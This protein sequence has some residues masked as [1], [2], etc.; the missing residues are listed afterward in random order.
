MIIDTNANL[1][2]WPFRRT[3]CDETESLIERLDR[4]QITSAWTGSLDGLFHRDVDG[5]NKRL[6]AECLKHRQ[7][8]PFGTVNPT[9]P[10]WEQ[11]L[12][13]CH[14]LYMM[15]GIRLHPNYHGYTI[16]D[17]R[18]KRLLTMAAERELIVQLAIRMD[19]TRVQH[20]LMQVAD[21]DVEPLPKLVR[22]VPGLRLM[23][24]NALRVVLQPAIG[25]IVGAGDVHVEISML[26]GLGCV[27]KLLKSIPLERVHFGSHLPLF[28]VESALLKLRESELT[29]VELDAIQYQN[30]SRLA[31]AK[32]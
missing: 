24:I 8:I 11:D 29:Q 1:S 13:R 9:L 25:R 3:P 14:V 4:S 22:E 23:L 18:L 26:E 5:V 19:D 10:D 7:L 28:N 12:K 20:H 21:V 17:P 27:G 15:P 30:A 2:R 31:S 16:D 6:F 32:A